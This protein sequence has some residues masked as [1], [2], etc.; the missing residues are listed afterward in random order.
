M[1][2]LYGDESVSTVCAERVA[3][4]ACSERGVAEDQITKRTSV[5]G[6]GGMCSVGGSGVLACV[7]CADLRVALV[8]AAPVE[9]PECAEEAPKCAEEAP[10][11]A[12]APDCGIHT[13][14]NTHKY[15]IYLRIYLSINPSI[16]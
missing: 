6:S 4:N 15:P 14:T 13:Y 2:R 5:G 11:C 8:P 16:D 1:L 3:E 9:A 7:C 12:E 10:E